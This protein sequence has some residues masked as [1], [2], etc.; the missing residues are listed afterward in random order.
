LRDVH[1]VFSSDYFDERISFLSRRIIAIT[2]PSA[3]RMG[4][5]LGSK[6]KEVN[7]W[8]L[9]MNTSDWECIKMENRPNPQNAAEVG[10]CRP[11]PYAML[12]KSS[13]ATVNAKQKSR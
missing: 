5:S 12:G 7:K 2:L 11:P 13:P 6:Y 1:Q 9:N 3:M 4:A 8:K 10:I